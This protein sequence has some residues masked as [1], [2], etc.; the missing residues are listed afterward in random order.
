MPNWIW[1]TIG[2]VAFLAFCWGFN[3]L[4]RAAQNDTRS[5][6]QD[7]SPVGGVTAPPGV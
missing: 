2:I 7:S 4:L 5:R 6:G 3:L 1:W